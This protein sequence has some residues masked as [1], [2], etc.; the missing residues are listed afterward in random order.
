MEFGIG[1]NALQRAMDGDEAVSSAR[2]IISNR[3]IAGFK[4]WSRIRKPL[5]LAM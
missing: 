5:P 2:W 3:R 1:R 4:A